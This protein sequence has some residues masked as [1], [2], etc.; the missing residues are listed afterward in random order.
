MI[1]IVSSEGKIQAGVSLL[2]LTSADLNFRGLEYSNKRAP[3]EILEARNCHFKKQSQSLWTISKRTC[4]FVTSCQLTTTTLDEPSLLMISTK[5]S[6]DW[7]VVN[8]F[9]LLCLYIHV[10]LS[11]TIFSVFVCLFVCLFVL[12]CVFCFL[13]FFF[14]FYSP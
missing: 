6:L 7:R 8:C 1:A 14:L 2:P 4:T 9:A 10:C 3:A 12:F 13:I 11:C 5:T